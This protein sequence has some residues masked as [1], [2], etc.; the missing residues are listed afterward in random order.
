[1]PSENYN[2][3]YTP[4]DEFSFER[5]PYRFMKKREPIRRA[6]PG[7]YSGAQRDYNRMKPEEQQQMQRK[8]KNL[9]KKSPKLAATL[10]AKKPS[11]IVGLA[12]NLFRQIDWSIDWLFIL[13]ISF[14]LL[15][16]IFDIA[17]AALGAIPIIGIAGTAVG[18]I[19]SFV[20]DLMFLIL[21][22]TVLYLVGSS[23]KNRGLAKY[24]VGTAMEFIAEALPGISWL[25]WTPVY[26]LVLYLFVL[27][28]RACAEQGTQTAQTD[29]PASGSAADGYQEQLAA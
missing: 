12:K 7:A 3:T 13:L 22:V 2:S 27:F 15:K 9:Q 21:T 14:G 18:I 16:D 11:A 25:P 4:G 8:L 10:A 19:V 17:F 5:D 29:I 20:G 23:F 1:M 26:V 28:D 24:F 6:A